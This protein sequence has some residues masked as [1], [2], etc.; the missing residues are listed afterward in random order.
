MIATISSD[1]IQ[2]MLRVCARDAEIVCH[3]SGVIAK[4]GDMDFPHLSPCEH[5]P[6]RVPYGTVLFLLQALEVDGECASK[7]LTELDPN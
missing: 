1:D 7:E 2:A 4:R 5:G 6:I 3:K